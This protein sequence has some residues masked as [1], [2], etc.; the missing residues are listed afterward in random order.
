MANT[1]K[2]I[3]QRF[4]GLAKVR[5]DYEDLWQDVADLVAPRRSD[6]DGTELP[7][8]K[9]GLKIYDGTPRAACQQHA[10]G[11]FGYLCSPSTVWF[12]LKIARKDI[13]KIPEV[14]A[15]LQ[16]ATIQ[17]HYAFTRSNFYAV[18]PEYFFD[19]CSI[20]TATMYAE[21]DPSTGKVVF[22]PRHP[23]EIYIAAN[24][25]GSVDVL[26]RKF[27]LTARN[28]A[29]QFPSGLSNM[30]ISAAR[31]TPE[32][33]FEFLHAVYPNDD[34][35]LGKKNNKNMRYTSIYTELKG[36]DTILSHGGY[37]EFPYSVWRYR[38]S[39]GEVYGRSPASDA[40]VEIL[41]LNQVTK[42]VLK[43]SQLAVEPAYNVPKEMRGKV[44]IAPKG[45]NY[46][47]EER[48]MITPVNVPTQLPA[49]EAQ[50]LRMQKA[51]DANFHIDFFTLLSRA[52]LDGRQLTVPQV[53]EM[54]GE[55]GAMLGAVVGRLNG[56][57]F[58]NCIDRMFQLETKAGRMPEVPDVLYESGETMIETEYMG[59]LAQAQRQQMRVQ[60]I[61]R[62]M[63]ILSPLA[64]I[65]P[66]ILDRIDF[67]E[68]VDEVFD[69]N[70][71][72]T[73]AIIPLEQA[74]EMR[75]ARAQQEQQQQ[76]AQMMSEAADKVPAV[77][78]E[79]AD[80]SVL[81]QLMGGGEE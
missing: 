68:L 47:D 33:E 25:Y 35:Q 29:K 49:G 17:L 46:Y 28:A 77:T 13:S 53:I 40:L 52:A 64:E 79:V 36:S 75:A 50:Q 18:T 65:N 74:N 31:N 81:N 7:G 70:S 30:I 10:D 4:S 37:N 32:A 76:D 45:M 19:G 44:R 2:E 15:Y 69:A 43:A 42:S 51:I 3:R 73:D 38:T 56:D 63:D 78:G 61:T 59:I 27:K 41:G 14:R 34:K 71:F 62:T 20:G 58:D 6:I 22:T 16:D 26:F 39:S 5:E 24:Q 54:Q 67:D 11:L 8:K 12:N 21:E 72:P 23:R 55:K 57:F 48:R 9:R 66:S 1:A 60:S 80:S